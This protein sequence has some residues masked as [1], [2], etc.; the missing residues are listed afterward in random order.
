M[1]RIYL[2][3]PGLFALLLFLCS[4][5]RN[6]TTTDLQPPLPNIILIMS[7]DQGWGDTGYNG[8]P[9]LKTPALDGMASNG[10][11]FNR[12]YAASAV[13]S[14][15]RGSVMTGRHPDRYGICYAN[16]GHLPS[17][18]ITL[19]EMLKLKGYSTGHFGKWHLG[20][21][22]RDTI[23]ANR[24]GRPENNIHYSPPWENGFDVCFSTESKVPTWE[25]MVVPPK[26]A[27]DVSAKLAEGESFGT[28]YWNGPGRIAT[29]NLEGDDSRI[30]MDRVIPFIDKAVDRNQPFLSV[31]WFHS[32]H[33]PVLTGEAYKNLYNG[34][35]ED[36][37]H[38]YGV[39]TAM[40]E[41]IGRLRVHLRKLEVEENTIL[42]FTSDNGPEGS[43]IN[44]RTQG[45]TKGLTGRKRSLKEGGIRVPG[46]VEWP[47]HLTPKVVAHYPAFTSDYFPTIASLIGVDI[48][49]YQRI[50]D[51]LDLMPAMTMQNPVRQQSMVFQLRDQIAVT[52]NRFKIYSPDR[53]DNFQLFDIL[54]DPGEYTDLSQENP[55]A[56]KQLI[57]DFRDWKAGFVKE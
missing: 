55:T 7:D 57:E 6:Q 24:G 37:K 15:T 26:S 33:L 11:V 45:E 12:F 14:P 3:H 47:G 13:C 23:D 4:C 25:P 28:Y 48:G 27:G 42:F 19:A 50:Y 36:Q 31:I 34:L 39:I 30:I 43:D 8:H 53:G 38:Y 10:V 44:G 20:T 54:T 49:N 18:E 1:K 32:P 9:H 29:S 40:D 21:L 56:K 35:S 41:Q 17:D 16:C 51:G 52:D 22:T 5:Q 46:I 2:T